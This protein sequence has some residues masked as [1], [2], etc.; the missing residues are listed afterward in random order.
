MRATA[1]FASTTAAARM[2][3]SYTLDLAGRPRSPGRGPE[4]HGTEVFNAIRTPAGTALIA[5]GN[6]NRVIEV[7]KDGKTLL[8]HPS[9]PGCPASP[10]PG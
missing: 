1:R 9:R 4:G 5:A 3:W 7:D 2:I 8:D 6:G 10:W